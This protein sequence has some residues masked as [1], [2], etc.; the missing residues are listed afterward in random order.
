MIVAITACMSVP[1]T[2]LAAADCQVNGN[3]LEVHGNGYRHFTPLSHIVN[4]DDTQGKIT[5]TTTHSKFECGP[6]NCGETYDFLKERISG[7]R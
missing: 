4:V 7:K 2:A 1:V 5:I 6:N 3:I